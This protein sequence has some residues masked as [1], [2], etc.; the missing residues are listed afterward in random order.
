MTLSPTCR[1]IWRL[2]HEGATGR[3]LS[4]RGLYGWSGPD[5]ASWFHQPGG[6][7]PFDLGACNVTTLTGLLGPPWRVTS[8]GTVA[9]PERVVGNRRIDATVED[10]VHVLTEF[11]G[12]CVASIATGF[13]MQKYRVPGI[14]ICGSAGTVQMIGEDWGPKGLGGPKALSSGAT[15]APV[16]RCTRAAV[17]DGPTASAASCRPSRRGANPSTRPSLPYR[18][19][20]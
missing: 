13:T 9:I 5:W 14:A 1:D 2:I 11:D 15:T 4:A 6:G 18:C 8:L 20:R 3:P 17:G 16:G 7:P 19:R 10:G 12:G